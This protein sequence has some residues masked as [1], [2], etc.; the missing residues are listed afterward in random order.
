ML[1][2]TQ[3]ANVPHHRERVLP[4]GQVQVILN[5]ARDFLLDCP[6]DA[7]IKRMAPSLV[8]GARSVYEIVDSS[9]MAELIGIVFQPGGFAPFASDAVDI[10][11]N[12]SISL[13][14]VWGVSA[15]ELRDL[16][17]EA[18]SPQAKFRLM[19][20]FLLRCFTVRISGHKLVEFALSRFQKDSTV[21]RVK[22]VA[23]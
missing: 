2:Y 16:L 7:A 11:S 9:D 10:F 8:V 15:R 19:E 13:E 1:W 20:N 22:E 17:R 23:K 3:A 12:Q 14:D 5:L 6:E 18:D 21:S 4:G